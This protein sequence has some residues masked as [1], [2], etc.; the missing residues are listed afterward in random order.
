[1]T[2]VD[3]QGSTNIWFKS[4]IYFIEDLSNQCNSIPVGIL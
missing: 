2:K 4:I 3:S 1:M